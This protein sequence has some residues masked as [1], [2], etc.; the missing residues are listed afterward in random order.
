M[1]MSRDK[2]SHPPWSEVQGPKEVAGIVFFGPVDAGIVAP[3]D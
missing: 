2:L 1:S 3:Q